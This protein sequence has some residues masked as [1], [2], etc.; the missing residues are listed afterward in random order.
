MDVESEDEE[1]EESFAMEQESELRML[2]SKEDMHKIR[3]KWEHTLI[4]RFLTLQK[5]TPNFRA[6]QAYSNSVA[7]LILSTK[8]AYE[9]YNSN[10]L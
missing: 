2:L 3:K 7:A 9:Y 1:I 4:G 8:V 5:W 10:I 6:S